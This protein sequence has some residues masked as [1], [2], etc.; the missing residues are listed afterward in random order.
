[1]R[2]KSGVKPP[3]SK[4]WRHAR[5]AFLLIASKRRHARPAFLLIASKRRHA[6]PTFLLIR[7][8]SLS[9]APRTASRHFRA[10][11]KGGG[12]DSLRA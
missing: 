2:R 4:G 10:C 1:M 8:D 9:N 11:G 12:R 7:L 6:R 5:P 3:Q